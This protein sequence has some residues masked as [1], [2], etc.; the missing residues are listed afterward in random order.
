MVRLI[1]ISLTLFLFS[2]NL[3]SQKKVRTE[4]LVAPHA[5]VVSA[6]P[7]ASNIGTEILQRGGNAVDAAVAVHF[8]LAVVFPGAGNIGGG[9]FLLLREKDG[10]YTSLDF[11]EKAPAAATDTMYLD[12][13]GEIIKNLSTR[14]HL[15]S[16]VPGSVAGMAEAHRKYGTLPWKEL[17]QPAIN[18]A[19]NGFQ[20]T[21]KE[22]SGLNSIQ[23]NLKKYNTVLPQY[24]IKDKWNKD[25]IIYFTELGHTLERIRDQGA[26][27]FYKG[28]TAD[29]IVKEMQR[30]KGLITYEDL[31]AYQVVW[32]EPVTGYY[33]KYK[34]TSMPPPSSGGI[35]LIQLLKAVEPYPLKKWGHNTLKSVHL[36][37][38]AEKRVYADRSK[39]VGDPDFSVIPVEQLI[40]NEFIFE[41]MSSFNPLKATPAEEIKAGKLPV[42]PE[43]EETTHFSIVDP[44][45][46]AVAV[47][48]TI[49]GTYGSMVVVDGAGFFLNNEMDD[50]C[51]KPGTSN[52]FGDIGGNINRI[53]PGKRMLS[54]MTPTIIE[55]NNELFMVVGTPGGTTIITSVFQTILNVIE[56]NMTMQEAVSAKKF[57]NQWLPDLITV[58]ENALDPV[59]INSLTEMGHKI[60]SRKSIGRVDAILVLKNRGYEGGADP[61]GDDIASGF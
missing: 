13:N 43:S 6:H 16:G 39:Y 22:A 32:R 40:S 33:K 23:N 7:L 58:E 9:G 53:E 30:G 36:M 11:R 38:E 34:I 49:N 54:S 18:L 19:L 61:R 35:A 10:K 17:I 27:G 28:K 50:F 15:A 2:C 45:G 1:L 24:L 31:A 20:L 41:R 12:N 57:H 51:S 52:M 46:N 59:I 47:T 5:M 29:Y 4:G 48:T 26:D 55:K 44:F 42:K 60:E 14:G 8:T 3:D 21:A 56:H 37:T 25:D